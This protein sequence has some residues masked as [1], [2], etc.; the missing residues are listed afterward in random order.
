[1]KKSRLNPISDKRYALMDEEYEIRLKLIARCG[2]KP[3]LSRIAYT[4]IKGER[5]TLRFA[6]CIGGFCEECGNPPD[7][8]GLHPHEEEFRS[9]GGKLTLKNS[10]MLCGK[11]HAPKHGERI[12][13]E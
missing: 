2:G 8:T 1:M 5:R 7:F 11:C 9:R 10:K 4:T 6:R 13:D 3:F 12:V